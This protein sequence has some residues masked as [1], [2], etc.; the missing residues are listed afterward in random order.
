MRTFSQ[1]EQDTWKSWVGKRV[2]KKTLKPFKST[3]KI[4]TVKGTC[5]HPVTGH[6]CFTFEE[7]TSYVEAFRC[8]LYEA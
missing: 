6:L 4:G 5:T 2:E 3:F 7:D 1:E 8:R